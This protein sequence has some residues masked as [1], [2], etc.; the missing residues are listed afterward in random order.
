VVSAGTG[1]FEPL[2][3]SAEAA[4]LLQ[5]HPKTI[6][7]MARKGQVPGHR[8]GDLWRFRESELDIWLK[9][10]VSSNGHSRLEREG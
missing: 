1:P 8:I 7:R 9:A 2:I 4:G 5:I 10:E 6:Q 3:N